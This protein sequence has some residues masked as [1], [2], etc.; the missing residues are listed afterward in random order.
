MNTLVGLGA[1]ASFGVSCVAAALPRL[2]W[3]TFFE[4]PAMLLGERG[5]GEGKA[6]GQGALLR[7]LCCAAGLLPRSA[8]PRGG[9][10]GGSC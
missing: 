2:G 3:P 8:R 7:M 6:K 4:E 10:G 9:G 5:A 1:G